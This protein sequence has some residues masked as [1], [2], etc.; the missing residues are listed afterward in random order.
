MRL[1][2]P[3]FKSHNDPEGWI[4]ALKYHGYT[5]AF[6]PIREAE[7]SDLVDAYA[8]AA[9]ENDIVIAEVPAFGNNPISP[10]DATRKQGIETCQQRLALADQIGARCCV[11]VA[12]SRAERWAAPH[13]DS[14]TED[15]F[16]LIVQSIREI[17]DGANPKRSFYTIEMMPW[18][19]PD[20]ADSNLEL[21]KAIDRPQ[22]A[23]HFDPVN[24][25]NSPR[26]YFN[27]GALIKECFDKLG[28]YIKSCHAK[29]ILMHDKLTVHLDEV[30]P[31]LGN[32]DYKTFLQELNKLDPNTPLMVEH[33]KGEEE[34]TR[35]ADHIRSVATQNG[36]TL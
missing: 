22:L 34:Y 1:G 17:I 23:V 5:A 13:E 4:A 10:D 26:R 35:A 28:P 15:T 6:S 25:V 18:M 19:I 24:I 21:L 12:G 16:D 27:N 33:L 32:L 11:N 3:V 29:D 7:D 2:G 14:Y 36:I 9:E 20:S 31:G 30:R 8:K